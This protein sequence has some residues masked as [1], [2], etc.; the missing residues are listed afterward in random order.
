MLVGLS[1]SFTSTLGPSLSWSDSS[2]IYNYMCK[3]CI[4]PQTLWV[5]IPPRRGVLDTTL[6]D[7]VCQWLAAGRW[8]SPGI[9]VSSTNKTDRHG[10]IKILKVTLNTITITTLEVVVCARC[11]RTTLWYSLSM[12]VVFSGYSGSSTNKIY[13]HDITEILLK[14]ALHTITP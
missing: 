13:R 8:F 9:P 10:I 5:R 11:T 4:S 6:C 1:W 14:V 2:W 3:Q 12:S 7:K